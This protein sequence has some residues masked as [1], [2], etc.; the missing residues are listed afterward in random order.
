MI[1]IL[2]DIDRLVI[3]NCSI[4]NKKIIAFLFEE[5][6]ERKKMNLFENYTYSTKIK[7]EDKGN[8]EIII[9]IWAACLFNSIVSSKNN[10]ELKFKYIANEIIKMKSKII[11][12]FKEKCM[13]S[14]IDTTFTKIRGNHRYLSSIAPF[15]LLFVIL[16]IILIINS[17]K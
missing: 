6:Y 8:N 5:G 4:N 17:I 13:D 3:K 7:I 11:Y 10:N 9:D 14:I 12:Y 16:L 1:N 15:V 2:I